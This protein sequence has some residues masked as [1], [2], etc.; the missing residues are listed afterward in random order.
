MALN[1]TSATERETPTIATAT[2]PD[3]ELQAPSSKPES[4]SEYESEPGCGCTGT[5][6][7]DNEAH[8]KVTTIQ[9]DLIYNPI[10]III[11]DDVCARFGRAMNLHINTNL[12][13]CLSASDSLGRWRQFGGSGSWWEPGAG[14]AKQS[15]SGRRSL[16][17]FQGNR[18][19]AADPRSGV[20]SS[21]P[22]GLSH[23]RCTVVIMEKD[24][25]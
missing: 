14:N 6:T 3:S 9:C 1:V 12:C 11:D 25:N 16:A 15:R 13:L 21:L 19:A 2:N 10:S 17:V 4:E 23:R 24:L 22:T 7:G 20:Q 18:K 8:F 5:G